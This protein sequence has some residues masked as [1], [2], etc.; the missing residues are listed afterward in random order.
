M[1]R[2]NG[3]GEGERGK[4]D[5]EKGKDKGKV[6]RPSKADSWT[7]ER[8]NSLPLVE[9]FK[10]GEKR[11][12]RQEEERES[13]ESEVFKR[14]VKT[15]R[16]PEK[17]VEGNLMEILKEMREGF[18]EV[19]KEIR[20]MRKSREELKEWMEEMRKSWE[21]ENEGLRVRLDRLEKRLEEYEKGKRKGEDEG[22][23]K[24]EDKKKGLESG[25]TGGREELV[26]I[27]ERMRRLELEGE[28]R[29]REDRKRNIIIRGV[30]VKEEGL[31]GLRKEVEEIVKAT[32]AVVKV[33]GVRRLG[34]K[35]K[36]GREMVWVRF[37]SVGEKIEVMKG[38]ARLRDRGEWIED[39]LTEKERRINW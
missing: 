32:G 12:E 28:K 25:E 26:D 24:S 10:R 14:S 21:I 13:E 4:E 18:R 23:G 8:A 7:R 22:K 30:R 35:G 6:G 20:E 16:S 9:L 37:P 15:K 34:N 11:K 33:D 1:E 31:E 19:K 38:K 3:E 36:E 5:F 39:D 29:K 2:G 17:Q 27:K